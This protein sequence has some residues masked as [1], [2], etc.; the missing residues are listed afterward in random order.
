MTEKYYTDYPK[1][2]IGGGNPYYRCSYCKK[3]DP[4]I[5]GKIKNHAEW[6]EYRINKMKMTELNKNSFFIYFMNKTGGLHDPAYLTR[7]INLLK[8]WL[9]ENSPDMGDNM[10]EN[11]PLY[12]LGQSEYKQFIM[13]NLK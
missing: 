13:E 11:Y 1:E 7:V 6:C 5:N 12:A 2:P 10:K 9:P 8:E 4:E 3:S